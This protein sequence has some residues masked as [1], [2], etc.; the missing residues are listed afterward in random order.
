MYSPISMPHEDENFLESYFL[1]HSVC[2]L[3]AEQIGQNLLLSQNKTNKVTFFSFLW[4]P[5]SKGLI[6]AKIILSDHEVSI[7]LQRGLPVIENDV[8]KCLFHQREN[9]FFFL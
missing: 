8:E 4:H 6:S 5:L 2:Q 7:K 1:T 9:S 3:T